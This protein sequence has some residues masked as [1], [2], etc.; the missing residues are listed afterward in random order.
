[1]SKN[2]VSVLTTVNAPYSN[3]LDGAMLAHC[4]S[5]IE[6]AKVFSG[7]VSSF[8]GEVPL[9]QQT[10]FAAEFGIA[11]DDLKMLA[12]DFSAWSGESYHLAA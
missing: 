5:D 10:E 8:F 12:S 9:D 6:L 11:V 3:Q 4:L 1:M 7:Q 2:L